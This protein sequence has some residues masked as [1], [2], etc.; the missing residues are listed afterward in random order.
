MQEYQY[1]GKVLKCI[2]VVAI[3]QITSI[4]NKKY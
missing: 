1:S 2:N 4:I 3:A